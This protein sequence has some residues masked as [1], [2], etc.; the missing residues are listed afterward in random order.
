MQF[1]LMFSFPFLFFT[2]NNQ[3]ASQL[4]RNVSIHSCQCQWER[5]L[6]RVYVR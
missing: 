5:E 3:T 1:T 6:T 2:V 4:L